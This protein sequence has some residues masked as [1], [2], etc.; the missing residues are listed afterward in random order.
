LS[1]TNFGNI[2]QEKG[3]LLRIKWGYLIID[4]VLSLLSVSFSFFSFLD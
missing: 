3:A 1:P 2:T 4:E